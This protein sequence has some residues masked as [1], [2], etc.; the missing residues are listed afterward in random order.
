[1][2]RLLPGRLTARDFVADV[3]GKYQEFLAKR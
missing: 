2:Q 1:V 3:Q